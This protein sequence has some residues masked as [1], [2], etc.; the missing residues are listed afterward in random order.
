MRGASRLSTQ[1]WAS[2][3]R[4]V[5]GLSEGLLHPKIQ[6]PATLG[7]LSR[8]GRKPTLQN[9]E[10]GIRHP[11][12]SSFASLVDKRCCMCQILQV[13]RLNS[14]YTPE[15]LVSGYRFG[16]GDLEKSPEPLLSQWGFRIGSCHQ[17]SVNPRFFHPHPQICKRPD[18]S[19]GIGCFPSFF[20]LHFPLFC[21][22]ASWS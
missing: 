13:Q 4:Q 10:E 8:Q 6:K 17:K 15:S 9:A 3:A 11:S 7:L 16:S 14:S 22:S 19:T 1:H 21:C 5:V 18:P 20:L 2:L 12:V